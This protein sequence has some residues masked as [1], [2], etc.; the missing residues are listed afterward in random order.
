MT[1]RGHS[2]LFGKTLAGIALT[3][4]FALSGQ[5]LRADDCQRRVGRADHRLHEAI[6]HRGYQSEEAEPCA[7]RASRGS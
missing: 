1:K 7:S 3:G 4:L 2:W 5:Q 6:E